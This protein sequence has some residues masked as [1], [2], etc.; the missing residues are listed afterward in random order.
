M[1]IKYTKNNWLKRVYEDYLG[2]NVSLATW[3]RIKQALRDNNLEVTLDSL[4]LIAS[5]KLSFKDSKL[6]L[7]PLLSGY[8]KTTN[9]KNMKTYKGSDVFA[10]LKHIAGLK[11]SSVTIIRWFRDVAKDG[12]GFR[13]NQERYYTAQELHPVYLRAYVY[14]HKYGAARYE[15]TQKTI[16]IKPPKKH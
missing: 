7:T 9:L 16:D 15:L 3:Y 10:E 13:F 1:P 4:K 2:S 11:C 6:P 8:L 14:R 5:L 12:Q